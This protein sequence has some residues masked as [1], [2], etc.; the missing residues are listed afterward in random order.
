M[1][2]L[3][4]VLASLFTILFSNLKGKRNNNSITIYLKQTQIHCSKKGMIGIFSY[5]LQTMQWLLNEKDC[6]NVSQKRKNFIQYNVSQREVF[7]L[8]F[9]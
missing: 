3:L 6:S 8:S 5:F 4:L 9:T 2:I 1:I 7:I